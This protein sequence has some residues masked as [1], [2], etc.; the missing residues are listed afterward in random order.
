MRLLSDYT[1]F[2]DGIFDGSGPVFHRMAYTKGGLSKREQLARFD[3]IGLKTPPHGTV[4]ELAEQHR[5]ACGPLEPPREIGD[6][7]SC[8]VYC[9]E[10]EHRG[11]GKV[12]VPLNEALN[13]FPGHY[14]TLYFPRQ[15]SPVSFRFVRLGRR[16]FWLRQRGDG[17]DWRSNTRDHEEVLTSG[18]TSQS[19]PFARVLWAIDF[20]PSPLGLLAVDFNTAPNLIS[21]GE[22]GAI[23]PHEVLAELADAAGRVPEEL[24]QF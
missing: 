15:G 18:V 9:D 6:E 4:T 7:S 24:A 14:A 2:Y 17:T 20:I 3:K 21:L 16:T 13:R 10:F 23:A 1:Q 8:V 19:N 5:R 12:L 22:Q 11:Q